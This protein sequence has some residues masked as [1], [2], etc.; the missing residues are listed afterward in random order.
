LGYKAEAA[1]FAAGFAATLAWYLANAS[2]WLNF[3]S[4]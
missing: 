2:W 3:K 1:D 4:A